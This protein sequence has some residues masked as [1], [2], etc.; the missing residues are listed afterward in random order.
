MTI[1][2][3]R[4]EGERKMTKEFDLNSHLF[5]AKADHIISTLA[6]IKKASDPAKNKIFWSNYILCVCGGFLQRYI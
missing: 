4:E 5:L 1:G 6:E 2:I 3:F